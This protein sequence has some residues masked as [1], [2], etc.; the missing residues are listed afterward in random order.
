MVPWH[1]RPKSVSKTPT[2]IQSASPAHEST[3]DD[4]DDS[5]QRNAVDGAHPGQQSALLLHAIRQPYEVAVDHAV[6]EI[7][8]DTELLVKVTAAGLNPI[9]WKS[10]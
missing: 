1:W 7:Q 5:F 4:V 2:Q 6:P 10:P 9:D 3:T 8:D